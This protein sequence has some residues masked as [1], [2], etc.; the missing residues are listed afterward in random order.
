MSILKITLVPFLSL[1]CQ[2]KYLW[3]FSLPI[4][5]SSE[6]FS[7]VFFWVVFFYIFDYVYNVFYEHFLYK[8][9]I[10]SRSC[11]F[12]RG[13]MK[14]SCIREFMNSKC[15]RNNYIFSG[16]VF[17]KNEELLEGEPELGNVSNKI[18]L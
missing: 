5:S 15:Y 14:M 1:K 11:K 7:D 6:T 10:I 8:G 9:E 3:L 13:A 18:L 12:Y 2:K 4:K 16:K 17:Q